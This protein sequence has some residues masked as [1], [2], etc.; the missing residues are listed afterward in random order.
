MNVTF[1]NPSLPAPGISLPVHVQPVEESLQRLADGPST[2]I[3][4][5]NCFYRYFNISFNE[6]G[7]PAT[8]RIKWLKQQTEDFDRIIVD[9]TIKYFRNN[10]TSHAIGPTKFYKALMKK[11][12]N[13]NSIYPDKTEML[14]RF[15][16]VAASGSNMHNKIKSRWQSLISP[17]QKNE[18]YRRLKQHISR[19]PE[20]DQKCFE[21]YW[22]TLSST[23]SQQ[24]Q[25]SATQNHTDDPTGQPPPRKRRKQNLSDL[26]LTSSYSDSD[27]DPDEDWTPPR[28]KQPKRGQPQTRKIE[29]PES[30][31]DD[32]VS[33]TPQQISPR[34]LSPAIISRLST[35]TVLPPETGLSTQT[36]T[37]NNNLNRTF[38]ADLFGEAAVL[39]PDI[40]CVGDS[41]LIG[42]IPFPPVWNPG[43]TWQT[44]VTYNWRYTQTTQE[45][46]I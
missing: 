13:E 19:H 15:R 29:T 28:R 6:D 26:L 22:E 17:N 38:L 12:I 3:K 16:N 34:R 36:A 33:S 8:N 42:G 7:T 37:E 18:T 45:L 20:Q 10:N 25:E 2:D 24:E 14:H 9:V 23:S 30:P 5:K 31:H 40:P 35:Q 21:T 39:D 1:R 44:L 46:G 32:T 41:N 43:S 11:I 27:S 4:I